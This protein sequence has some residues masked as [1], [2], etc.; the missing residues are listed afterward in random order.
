VVLKI[1]SPRGGR[2][3]G[4]QTAAPVV[5]R[6]LEQALASRRVAIDRA[7]LTGDSGLRP[8][9]QDPGAAEEAPRQSVVVPWPPMAD[10]TRPAPVTVPSVTGQGVR[11]AALALHRRGLHVDL[12]GIGRVT[13]TDPVGGSSVPLRST[14]TVYTE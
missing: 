3:Y 2:I 7:R 14:V 11:A 12:R 6:M 8:P 9:R 1:D 13:R 10:T 5:R 4:G